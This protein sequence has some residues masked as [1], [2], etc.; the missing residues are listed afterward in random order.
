VLSI[1]FSPYFL[2]LGKDFFKT[3]GSRPSASAIA[4]DLVDQVV[5]KDDQADGVMLQV[6]Q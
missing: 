1:E 5:F 2:P 4:P 3:G 6:R